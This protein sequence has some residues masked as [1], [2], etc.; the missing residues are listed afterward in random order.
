MK[1][2][3]LLVVGVLFSSMSAKA[4]KVEVRCDGKSQYVEIDQ[5]GSS[6]S[7]NLQ[8]VGTDSDGNG[9]YKVFYSAWGQDGK[10]VNVGED[11]QTCRIIEPGA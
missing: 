10:L 8:R 3:A 6:S 2:K 5:I 9:I 4:L 7:L 1:F 11:G